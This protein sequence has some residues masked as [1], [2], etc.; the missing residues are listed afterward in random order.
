MMTCSTP[1]MA[2]SPI[3]AIFRCR[4]PTPRPLRPSNGSAR[5]GGRVT[6]LIH[7]GSE[8]VTIFIKGRD[9]ISGTKD[10][11]LRLA[12]N[13]VAVVVEGNV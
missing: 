13:D 6:F 7:H 5:D 1:F 2:G 11:I 3:T 12:P 9:L 4:T 8:P 10:D